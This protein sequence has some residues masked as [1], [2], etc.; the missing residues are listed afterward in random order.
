MAVRNVRRRR[1]IRYWIRHLDRFGDAAKGRRPP[2]LG[3]T[4]AKR[5]YLE[6]WGVGVPR[7]SK[8]RRGRR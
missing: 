5:Y 1:A 2:Y 4:P 8:R 3:S 7:T 6:K